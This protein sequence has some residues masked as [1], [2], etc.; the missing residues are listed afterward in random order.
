M[1]AYEL[2]KRSSASARR[3]ILGHEINN[4][5]SPIQSISESLAALSDPAKRQDDV[6]EDLRSGLGV[7]TRDRTTRTTSSRRNLNAGKG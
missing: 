1:V 4:P 3:E 2:M 7:R 5:V 6:E